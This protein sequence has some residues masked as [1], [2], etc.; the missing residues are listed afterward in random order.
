MLLFQVIIDFINSKNKKS[1]HIDID[2]N[3]KLYILFNL[4]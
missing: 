3:D 2:L 4:I 1:F